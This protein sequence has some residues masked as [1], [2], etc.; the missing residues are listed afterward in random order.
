MAEGQDLEQAVT[1]AAWHFFPDEMGLFE[2]QPT[3]ASQS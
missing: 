3:E 2:A 1:S